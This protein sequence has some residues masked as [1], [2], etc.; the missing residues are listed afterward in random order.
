MPKSL[1]SYET[2]NLNRNYVCKDSKSVNSVSSGESFDTTDDILEKRDT[3]NYEGIKLFSDSS[4]HIIST[5]LP[6]L[7]QKQR[8]VKDRLDFLE[9]LKKVG[10]FL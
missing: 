7:G 3:I 6:Q 5:G 9:D 4:N 2:C 8:G 1:S 10:K